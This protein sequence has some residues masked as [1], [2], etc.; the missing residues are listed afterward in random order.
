MPIPT[1]V[2]QLPWT[3]PILVSGYFVTG[4]IRG[5]ILQLVQLVVCVLL[6]IPFVKM[7][8]R[9]IYEQEQQGAQEVTETTEQ[10]K[11]AVTE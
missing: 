7:A 11:Q 6:W 2:A 5:A 9:R 10:T 8:D 3:T 1:G 4:S